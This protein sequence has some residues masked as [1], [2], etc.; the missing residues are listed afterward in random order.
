MDAEHIFQRQRFKIQFIRS[1]IIRRNRFR[2]TVY[3]NRLKAQLFQRQRCMDTAVVKL[4][5]LSN[6]VRPAAQNHNL[7][8]ICIDCALILHMITGVIVRRILCGAYMHA[9]PCLCDSRRKPRLTDF[10]LRHLQNLAQI[11]I[12]K[13]IQLRLFQHI[14]RRNVPFL[15]Q[16]GF[17]FFHQLFH[18]LN[19]IMFNFCQRVQFL[20]RRALAQSFVHNKLSLACRHGKHF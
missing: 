2:I 8:L 18:L 5:S 11:F 17:L 3:D 20:Y 12:G 6:T 16:Q 15:F 1:I 7:R 19:K 9:L 10:I 13:S 4:N 14:C